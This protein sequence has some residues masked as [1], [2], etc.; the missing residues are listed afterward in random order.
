MLAG[1]VGAF[2]AGFAYARLRDYAAPERASW[3]SSILDI[4]D[5]LARGRFIEKRAAPS[6]LVYLTIYPGERP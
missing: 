3:V 5:A 6:G 4:R 2:A 1:L